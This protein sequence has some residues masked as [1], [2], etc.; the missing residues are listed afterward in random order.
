[1][2]WLVLHMTCKYMLLICKLKTVWIWEGQA[3]VISN[4]EPWKHVQNH[5]LACA[6]FLVPHTACF[7]KLYVWFTL[8]ADVL[9]SQYLVL[10]MLLQSEALC[11]FDLWVI[12]LYAI[13]FYPYWYLFTCEFIVYFLAPTVQ[14]LDFTFC[15]WQVN[16]AHQ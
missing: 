10:T 7:N 12:K 3:H 9:L 14:D 16:K 5:I 11:M 6:S 2:D 4:F 8:R 15:V 13:K 1:M